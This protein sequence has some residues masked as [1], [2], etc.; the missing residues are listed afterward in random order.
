MWK[1]GN[2][3]TPNAVCL[4]L[5]V[6]DPLEQSQIEQVSENISGWLTKHLYN[7]D[8][9]LVV[10]MS[11]GAVIRQNALLNNLV[12]Q[13]NE[14]HFLDPIFTQALRQMHDNPKIGNDYRRIFPVR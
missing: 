11:E 9:K 12:V 13:I 2:V 1:C 7:P 6:M 8:I 3:Q 5:Q 10:V 4:V 14:P